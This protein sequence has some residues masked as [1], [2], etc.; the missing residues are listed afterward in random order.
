MQIA[1]QFGIE[2]ILLLAQIVNFI[3][4]L[5]VLRKFFYA[6]IVKM[7][8]DRKKKIEESLKNADAIES[9]LQQTE[10]QTQKTTQEAIK[11]AKQ[12]IEDAKQEAQR[13]SDRA[14]EDARKTQEEMVTAAQAQIEMQKEEM[15]KQLEKDTLTLVAGVIKKVLGKNLKQK[16]QQDLTDKAMSEI[17]NQLR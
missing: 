4:I 8:D 15:K 14:T 3:I 5:A 17:S 9:K 10:E 13:I 1:Q 16:D 12:I 7:L 2:P 6:P 11:S